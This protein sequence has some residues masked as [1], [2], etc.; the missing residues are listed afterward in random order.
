MKR[1]LGI[2]PGLAATGWGI[3]DVSGT[4]FTHVKHG[5]IKTSP[6]DTLG[7]RLDII[8]RSIVSIIDEFQP[9]CAGIEEIFFARNKISALPVAQAKGVILL[10]LEQKAITTAAYTPLQIKQALTGN[11]RADKNQVQDMVKLLLGLH[12][13]INPDHSADALAAAICYQNNAALEDYS[14]V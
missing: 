4:R 13:K 10:A 7:V 11:G 9:V 1:I 3:V 8:F 12:E 5:Y 2:D 6:S 14:H